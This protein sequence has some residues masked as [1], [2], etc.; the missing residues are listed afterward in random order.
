[1]SA[2]RKSVIKA[3]V[4]GLGVG[5]HHIGVYESEPRC[6]VVTL[7]DINEEKLADVGN[8]H[9]GKS[10]TT[11]PSAVLADPEIDVVSIASY[12]DAHY[13]QVKAAILASKHVF[14]EKPLCLFDEEFDD[15]DR[16]LHERP[17]VRLSSNFV[18]RRA[19]QFRE[20]KT[21][22][23]TGALG[24]LYYFEGDYNYG[25]MHKI[26]EGWRGK[27]PFYSVSHGGAIH[28]IDLILWLSQG[29]IVE[30]TALGNQITTAGS[31][32]RFPDLV[33]ALLR[34][35]DGATAKVTANFGCVC[36]HHHALSVFGTQGTFVRGHQGGF[37]YS[38]RDEHVVPERIQLAYPKTAKGDVQRAFL[39]HILDGTPPEVRAAE[40]MDAMAVSL[41][42]ER[43]LRSHRW[44]PV[45]Y[46]RVS[47]REAASSRK[48]SAPINQGDISK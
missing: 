24:R 30:V 20:L 29:R 6:K 46:G 21:R 35:D 23:E 11:S 32:F 37:Y 22:V 3:A 14:V 17:A 44:E 26:T 48:P 42:I 39:A 43:S 13:Q 25:R 2:V 33:T 15:I 47:G 41:A 27:I 45:R 40:V 38:S 1:M 28:L 8:R 36:P 34:F 4:I 7:C 18:L 12:D 9:P 10:L 19:P 5:E 31:N 16:L